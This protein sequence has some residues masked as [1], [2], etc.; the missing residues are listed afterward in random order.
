MIQLDGL[1]E[2]QVKLLDIIWNIDSMEECQEYIMSLSER[3]QMECQTLVKLLA[4]EV[5]DQSVDRMD[6]WTEAREV[7]GRVMA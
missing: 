7:I 5:L 2:R 1:T 4:I 3:D 6:D